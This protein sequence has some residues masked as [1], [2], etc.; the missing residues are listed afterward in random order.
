MTPASDVLYSEL[1]SRLRS[2]ISSI[3]A[4]VN[5]DEIAQVWEFVDHAE[6]GLALSMLAEL[7][8][9]D[10]VPVTAENHREI[11]SLA[12]IMGILDD[13]PSNMRVDPRPAHTA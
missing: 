1:D 6:Y 5:A 10:E 7:L 12:Q 13:L 2:L 9:L 8:V 11:I 4:A 3:G